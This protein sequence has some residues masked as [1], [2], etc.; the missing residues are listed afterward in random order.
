M[1]LLCDVDKAE[2]LEWDLEAKGSNKRRM[3]YEGE[4]EM[5]MV[6]DAVVEATGPPVTVV[7]G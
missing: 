3:Q 4:M 1:M 6:A 2:A 7:A 5:Q